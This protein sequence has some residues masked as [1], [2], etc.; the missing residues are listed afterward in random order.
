MQQSIFVRVV[1]ILYQGKREEVVKNDW[2]AY[3]H[4]TIEK[5]G[6][7]P[8]FPMSMISQ[9]VQTEGEVREHMPKI[10]SRCGSRVYTGKKVYFYH[11]KQYKYARLQ[12]LVMTGD[13]TKD[14]NV[15]YLACLNVEEK[16][17]TGL[18]R[19]WKGRKMLEKM[20]KPFTV[21]RLDDHYM[22]LYLV[23]STY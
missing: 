2:T 23:H 1:W 16:M 13:K 8:V 9:L 15:R 4:V 20:G 22:F 7:L 18:S 10:C 14:K 5:C 17:M 12:Q 3:V 21:Y 6:S 11:D 19:E